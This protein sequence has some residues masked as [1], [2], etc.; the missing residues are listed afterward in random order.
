MDSFN[1]IVLVDRPTVKTKHSD[2][3]EGFVH[4]DVLIKR[5]FQFVPWST[6]GKERREKNPLPPATAHQL[7]D[8]VGNVSNLKVVFS[9]YFQDNGRV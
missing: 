8:M 2:C 4:S 9:D 6:K 5:T 7:S 3:I 1:Q